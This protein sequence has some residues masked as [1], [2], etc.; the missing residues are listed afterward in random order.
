M[1]EEYDFVYVDDGNSTA[2]TDLSAGGFDGT[3][4]PGPFVSTAADGSLT[5]KFYSD[6]GVSNAGFVANVACLNTL[7]TQ[8]F[9]PNIDFTYY[10][11]PTSGQVSISSKT[12]MSGV[13]VYNVA[14]QLLYQ[15]S[16]NG[17]ETKVD[18][19]AFASGTYF[20]KLRFDDKEANFKIQK[21]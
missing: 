21:M 17:L 13:T 2:A 1:E 14:G 11:N 8:D 9:G 4:I 16:I 10:P 7:G 20:F 6:G 12:P 18:I 3:T 15:D 5:I 19:S